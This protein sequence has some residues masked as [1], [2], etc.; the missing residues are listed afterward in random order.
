MKIRQIALVANDIALVK[1]TLFTLLGIKEAHVDPKIISFGLQ[2][3]V[4][5]L[6]DTFLEVVSPVTEGTTA[7]RL[8]E[9]RNGDG[10][11]MV[12]VQVD[13]LVEE[14]A[15]LAETSIRVIWQTVSER[16]NAIHLHPKDVPGAIASL[17][18]MVPPEAWY[19]A[20]TEWQQHRAQWVADICAAEV[21]SD[22]PNTTA[23]QWSLAYGRPVIRRSGVPTLV[24]G[25]SEV[26]FVPLMDQR[27]PGL[28][29][30]DVN[31][32]NLAAVLEAA[33]Q[34]KLPRKGNA[35][36]V[37]GI[38]INVVENGCIC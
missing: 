36:N 29:S 11:Y 28:R 6:G 8:I 30:I 33:D 17:D 7:G 3:V 27:G 38:T 35:I 37:C 26:R 14:R 2:N 23:E 31:A 13:D 19:W 22:D 5:A 15:R 16:T 10:G 9:R 34:Q 20:G 18:Q 25:T 1:E 4:M 24:L 21:Q 12:I 32:I